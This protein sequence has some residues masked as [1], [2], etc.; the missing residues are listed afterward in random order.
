[1]IIEVMVIFVGDKPSK[2]NLD[3]EVA[4]VGTPSFKNLCKW[5]V[6]MQIVDFVMVN[7]YTHDDEVKICQ[8]FNN[9]L[10]PFVAL[11]RNAS[12]RLKSL[13]ISHHK[14]PHPSPKNRLLNKKEY[15][16][17]ELRKCSNWLISME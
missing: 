14:L 8:F 1:M 6:K 5:L 3:P 16:D 12:N 13:G 9:K 10:G 2:K 7:S 4:F 11:G 17:A 15:V